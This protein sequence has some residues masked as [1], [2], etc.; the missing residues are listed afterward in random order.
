MPGASPPGQDLHHVP[1]ISELSEL[2]RA[3]FA[4][5]RAV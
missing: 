1:S 5:A 3:Q 2:V 4:G